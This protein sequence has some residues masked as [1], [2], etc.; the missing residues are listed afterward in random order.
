MAAIATLT[1][2]IFRRV[3]MGTLLPGIACNSQR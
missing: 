3:C 1:A 2:Q